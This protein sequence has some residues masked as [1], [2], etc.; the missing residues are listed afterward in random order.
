MPYG[1]AGERVAQVEAVIA[2][3][4]A[5]FAG[6][7]GFGGA[8]QRSGPKIM[9]A[10]AGER[11]MALAAKEADIVALAVLPASTDD[12]LRRPVSTLR[13][14]AGARFDDIELSMNLLRVGSQPPPWVPTGFEAPGPEAA[15]VL[16]GS[17]REMADVLLRRRDELGVSY[18]TVNGFYA[19]ALA[20]VV[21]LLT[22]G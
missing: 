22:G 10:G 2:E 18:I 5:A 1:T 20:P 15:A 21:E 16:D 11:M 9:L 4:R 7:S 17:P 13:D 6:S 19:E 14:R 8:V 12:D 3:T